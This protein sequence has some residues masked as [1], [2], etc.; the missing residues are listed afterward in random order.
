M[1]W[2]DLQH[3][4]PAALYETSTG[5][6]FSQPYNGSTLAFYANMDMLA[7]V[8]VTEV[9]QTW[10]RV[11][12]VHACCRPMVMPAPLVTD[13]HPWRCWSSSRPVTAPRSRTNNN[14]YGGLDAEYNFNTGPCARSPRHLAAWREEGCAL[15]AVRPPATTSRP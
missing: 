7:N 5:A 12:E 2:S 15:N 4:A 6:M 14:G 13:G 11:I 8:G 3:R 9:P 1:D 10:E